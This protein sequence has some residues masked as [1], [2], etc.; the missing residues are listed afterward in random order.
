MAVKKAQVD[1]QITGADTIQSLEDALSS[2]NEEIKNVDINSS[3]FQNLSTQAETVRTKLTQVNESL[4]AV[5][6]QRQGEAIRK[7]GLSLVGVFQG[8]AGASLI[9]GNKVGADFQLLIGKVA[10]L[11]SVVDGISRVTKAF[12]TENIAA[13]K[14]LGTQWGIMGADAKIAGMTMKTA[15]LTSGIGILVVALGVVA[16]NWDKITNAIKRSREEKKLAEDKK[17]LDEELKTQEDIIKSYEEEAAAQKKINELNGKKEENARVDLDLAQKK[18]AEV[19]AQQATLQNAQATIQLTID[20]AKEDVGLQ[21][22]KVN[23]LES[24][25]NLTGLGI[26]HAEKKLV[27]DKL[28]LKTAEDE[29]KVN[30]EQQAANKKNLELLQ[31]EGAAALVLLLNQTKL[32]DLDKDIAARENRVK[33]LQA[34][35][36]QTVAIYEEQKKIIDLQIKKIALQVQIDG[37]LS[38]ENEQSIKNLEADKQALTIKENL[39][40]KNLDYQSKMNALNKIYNNNLKEN[41]GLILDSNVEFDKS[42]EKLNKALVVSDRQN[43]IYSEIV[44]GV[45]TYNEFQ[46]QSLTLGE[47][48]QNQNKENAEF[49]ALGNSGLKVTRDSYEKIVGK[50]AEYKQ[51]TD[52]QKAFPNPND[53]FKLDTLEKYGELLKHNND[54]FTSK[55]QEAAALNGEILDSD[56]KILQRKASELS[57]TVVMLNIEKDQLDIKRDQEIAIRNQSLANDELLKARKDI[58]DSYVGELNLVKN[59]LE[60]EKAAAKTTEQKTIINDKILAVEGSIVGAQNEQYQISSDLYKNKQDQIKADNEIDVITGQIVEN[61]QAEDDANVKITKEL[62]DQEQLYS[63]IQDWIKQNAELIQASS[64]LI[65]Q[66]FSLAIAGQQRVADKAQERIDKAQKQ[67]DKLNNAEAKSREKII[68]LQNELK[69]ADGERYNEIL[70]QIADEEAAQ[71]EKGKNDQQLVK[72]LTNQQLKAQYE[73]D[74][75]EWKMKK[76]EKVQAIISATIAGALAVVK[77]LP[78]VILAAIVGVLSAAAIATIAVQ[79]IPPQPEKPTYLAKGGLLEGNL[80]KDGGIQVGKTGIEVEGEEYVVNRYATKKYLPVLEAINN[81]GNKMKY[82]A[83]GQL[84]D[85]NTK[86]QGEFIDYDKLSKAILSGIQP[87]VSIV[88][89]NRGINRVHVIQQSASL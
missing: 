19:K 9:F 85:I 51:L 20:K 77:S 6:G 68:D 13:L 46:A 15:L 16:A 28:S 18:T 40:I 73:K 41:N 56:D 49:I 35:E 44:K 59:T 64:E 76:L 65:N 75:A 17:A 39:F 4:N 5:T 62:L 82:D 78:N 1:I 23:R 12:S 71:T 7:M 43:V 58:V 8:A 54:Y 79:K 86:Q 24:A 29:L 67:L 72:D 52:K 53:A 2:I 34:E 84:P 83:G 57:T 42:V 48:I 63:K 25:N 87:T 21:E 11:Y 70:K 22:I 80:H 33:I 88:D 38:K 61:K 14:S 32:N 69:D 74:M 89:I 31:K 36:G 60:A 50:L 81:S 45:K 47:E 66:M 3:A 37:F 10:G 27:T 26:K 30:L 55:L